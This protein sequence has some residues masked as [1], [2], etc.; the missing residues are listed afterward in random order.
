MDAPKFVEGEEVFA[1]YM[2]MPGC[3]T[4]ITRRQFRKKFIYNIDTPEEEILHNVWLYKTLECTRV[5]QWLRE[6]QL[7]KLPPEERMSWEDCL[8]QPNKI[9]EEA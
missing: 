1:D 4:E 3:R 7:R 5:K 9:E 2:T 6:S 8:F